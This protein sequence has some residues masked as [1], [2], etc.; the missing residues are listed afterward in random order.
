MKPK[1][2]LR[3]ILEPVILILLFLFA[4][5]WIAV[6]ISESISRHL[7]ENEREVIRQ[8]EDLH[9]GRPSSDD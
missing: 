5:V 7:A 2:D 4:V 9:V 6:S 1:S 3:R 8:C